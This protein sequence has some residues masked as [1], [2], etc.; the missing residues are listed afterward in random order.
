MARRNTGALN[1]ARLAAIVLIGWAAAARADGAI[2]VGSTGDV[3]KYGIAFGMVVDMPLKDALET[4]LTRCRSFQAREAA[5]FCKVVAIFSRECYAVAY[6]P[7]PGTPGAGWGV[8]KTQSEA[9][10]KSLAMC[11][12]TAGAGREKFCRVESSACDT[13]N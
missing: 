12:E 2:A 5:K 10:E 6:D 11:R 9:A 1:A 8:G 3:V 4:A 13:R 7:D